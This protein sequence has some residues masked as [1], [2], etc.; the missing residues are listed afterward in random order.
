MVTCVESVKSILKAVKSLRLN[1]T[2]CFV[3][4][5]SLLL[6]CSIQ[7]VLHQ[8]PSTSYSVQLEEGTEEQ[9]QSHDL[10]NS[11]TS[12]K[13]HNGHFQLLLGHRKCLSCVLMETV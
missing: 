13:S 3:L 2:V 4:Q 12:R 7:L 6:L 10:G 5:T 1:S 9:A 11:R 8:A